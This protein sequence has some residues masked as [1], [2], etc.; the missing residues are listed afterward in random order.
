MINVLFL[1]ETR[2]IP[3]AAGAAWN[4]AS[5]VISCKA[6]IVTVSRVDRKNPNQPVNMELESGMAMNVIFVPASTIVSVQDTLMAPFPV[7]KT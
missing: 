1:D 5:K 2:V 6:I 4:L 7:L 3:F